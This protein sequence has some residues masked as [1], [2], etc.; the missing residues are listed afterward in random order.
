MQIHWRTA[1]AIVFA[2][3]F[4]IFLLRATWPVGWFDLL[5]TVVLSVLV[6]FFVRYFKGFKTD[7]KSE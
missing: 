6:G 1:L 2:F 4:G 3:A 5:V 7:N